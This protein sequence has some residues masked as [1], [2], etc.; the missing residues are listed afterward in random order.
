MEHEENPADAR[1]PA[2]QQAKGG[3]GCLLAGLGAAVAPLAWAPKAAI[4]VDGGL[5]GHAR[6]LSVLYV[7]LPLIVLG[8]ALVPA[9]AWALTRRWTH[10]PWAPAL[11]AVAALALGVAGLLEWWTPEHPANPGD[12]PGI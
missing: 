7:D 6:D 10:R 4:S 9:L 11:V 1:E 2:G 12:G 8:G 5:E 3:L